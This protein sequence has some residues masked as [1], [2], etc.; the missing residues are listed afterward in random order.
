MR[1]DLLLRAFRSQQVGLEIL[2][3][4]LQLLFLLLL[5]FRDDLLSRSRF[6]Q[7]VDKLVIQLDFTS[8]VVFL[9]DLRIT[10][11]GERGCV[12]GRAEELLIRGE[13]AK[14][15][16]L[17]ITRLAGTVVWS[18]FLKIVWVSVFHAHRQTFFQG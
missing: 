17:V 8:V 1:F 18:L 9:G 5:R 13:L 7:L 15:V 16:S 10:L 4:I 11:L 12:L 6:Y 14:V 3:F 2:V